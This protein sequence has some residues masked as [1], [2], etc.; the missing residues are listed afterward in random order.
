MATNK[1]Q[2]TEQT[3]ADF[4]LSLDE[5]RRSECQWLAQLMQQATGAEPRMWG[6]AIVG[7][8][9]T[10]LVYESGRELDWFKIGFSPR[11]AALTLYLGEAALSDEAVMKRL[12]KHTT[13]KGCLYLK[14]L[15]DA[16]PAA[17]EALLQGSVGRG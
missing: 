7:F 8:G 3:A 1:T 12:G 2:A 16:E 9:E 11:K 14:R 6:A 13:G 17:L 10:H 15:D 4:F 5:P